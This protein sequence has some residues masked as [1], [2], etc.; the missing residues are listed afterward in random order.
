VFINMDRDAS[1]LLDQL[2]PMP[3]M[4]DPLLVGEMKVRWWRAVRL[5]ANW[6]MVNEAFLEGWHSTQ[7]HPQLTFGGDT[8][9]FP[10][11]FSEYFSDANGNSHF[12]N[13]APSVTEV[14]P[15]ADRVA[16]MVD[17][18]RILHN[19]FDAYPLARDVSLM[20]SLRYTVSDPEALEEQFMARLFESY[21]GAGMPLPQVEPT[22]Y[23]GWGGVFFMFPNYFILPMFGA[24]A[25]YRMRPD[26][27][28][29]EGCY[30]EVWAVSLRARHEHV[31]RAELTGVFDKNDVEGWPLVPRQDFSNIERQQ[32]G[33]HSPAFKALRLSRDYEQG[34]SNMHQELDRR[35]AQD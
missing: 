18:L 26:G 4:L 17:S 8:T 28:D 9:V 5:K 6:K 21:A 29:P 27:L 35:L 34:I 13:K 1:P 23:R 33:L 22:L 32:E 30:A 12:Y 3:S 24:A 25:I 7:T 14:A 11:D 19:T 2:A 10:H 16:S 15:D 20:E 31:E